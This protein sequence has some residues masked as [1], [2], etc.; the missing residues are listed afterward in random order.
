MAASVLGDRVG[1][2]TATV[3]QGTLT[4]GSALGA[5]APNV[6]SFQ[7]FASAGIVNGNVVS[8]LI[9]DSNGNW[10]VGTGTYSSSGTTLSRTV[11]YS[12]NSNTAISLSG[13]A[14]VFI[15]AR[16][17][18]IIGSI[19]GRTAAA[20][21]SAAG[22]Y[23]LTQIYNTPMSPGGRL[24]L[25]STLAVM[26]ATIS[27]ATTI[28]WNPYVHQLCP[29][30]DGTR[31][32][33]FDTGGQLSNI[34]TNSATGNAGPA[35]VGASSNY[36]LFIWNNSGTI[37]LTRGPAWSS[38]TS[39]GTGG[40]SAQIGQVNGI[41]TNAVSI[42]NGPSTNLG[43]YVGTVRS[44][45][46]STIDF[47]FGAA[48]SGGTA[49]SLGVWN[50]YNRVPIVT[51]VLDTVSSFTVASATTIEFNNSAT[52][53]V[54]FIVGL[55]ED[56]WEAFFSTMAASGGNN[57][58]AAGIGYDSTS[59]YSGTIGF[60]NNGTGGG[61]GT[62]PA[63]F[64]VI[65]LGFHFFQALVTNSF[66]SSTTATFYGNAGLSYCQEGLTVTGRV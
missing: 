31:F 36:D 63:K 20:I 56:S 25:S 61:N 13:T 37:T 28:Y 5:V 3:G 35:A 1:M 58:I 55:Q 66:T 48:A 4:L 12:S 62:I 51:Q 38:A 40:G 26:S 27:G 14:Q 53:R 9:L 30:Y 50:A 57:N 54:S 43:T 10:E 21:T 52:N 11:T 2:S 49:G 41:W 17:E 22:D 44:N 18:D 15:V 59:S 19:F 65:P 42:T 60:M 8:Y 45:G 47:I 32:S 23:A 64:S 34:T 46:S 6:C 29:I 16:A 39:R 7:S 24:S 33:V